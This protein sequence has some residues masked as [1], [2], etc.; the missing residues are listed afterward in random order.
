MEISNKTA[1]EINGRLFLLNW[2]RFWHHHHVNWYWMEKER[3]SE[4]VSES[5]KKRTSGCIWWNV[6]KLDCDGV[7]IVVV[8]KAEYL[9]N[10][11][12]VVVIN[13]FAPY[14][15]IP[16][17]VEI[18][19]CIHGQISYLWKEKADTKWFC[20]RNLVSIKCHRLNQLVVKIV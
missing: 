17:W 12:I 16:Y 9:N 18:V 4:S 5:E 1:K 8:I 3:K 20:F 15:I 6:I 11:K 19:A 7:Y 13:W 14:H 2:Y 10:K